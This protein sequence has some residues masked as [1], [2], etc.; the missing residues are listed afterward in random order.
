[1]IEMMKELLN[2]IL[3]DVLRLI[4]FTHAQFFVG[5]N[6]LKIIEIQTGI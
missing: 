2:V 5:K 4:K 1:M 6:E 3:F